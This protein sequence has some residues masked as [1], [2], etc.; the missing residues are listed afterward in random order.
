MIDGLKV[1]MT[2][3]DLRQLLADR[4]EVHRTRAARWKHEMT[5]TPED[6]TE[7]APLLPEHMCEFEAGR[8]EWRAD[9][10]DFLC[11]HVEPAEVYRLGQADLEF[12]E[13][14]PEKPGDLEQQ[15]Y[16]ERN[17]VGFE[18]E[19]LSRRACLAPEIWH[20]TNPAAPER[21]SISDTGHAGK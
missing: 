1:T 17:R 7:E 14:L 19:R 5:R 4:A 13:L 6:Q 11:E 20:V 10:F 21:G 2:G 3:E 9:V 15:E 12:G 16:E 8:E 18:L